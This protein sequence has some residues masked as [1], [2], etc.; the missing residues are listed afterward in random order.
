M[1]LHIVCEVVSNPLH[2]VDIQANG[3]HFFNQIFVGHKV[4]CFGKVKK[5][6]NTAAASIPDSIISRQSFIAVKSAGNVD[7]PKKYPH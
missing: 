2:K 3:S 7:F 6:K 1:I 5:K 4:K